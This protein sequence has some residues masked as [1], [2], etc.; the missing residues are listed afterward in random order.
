MTA[1]A[2]AATPT[3]ATPPRPRTIADLVE[4]HSPGFDALR[5]VLAFL[6]LVS[7]TWPL[8]GF[9]DEPRSPLAPTY[10]TLGGFAVAGFFAMSGLLVGRSAVRRPLGAFARAR[11]LRIVPGYATAVI[12]T[13]L[14]VAGLAWLHEH[15]GLAGF[16]DA[17][18][19]GPLG[20][21]GRW[22]LFGTDMV[23]GVQGVFTSSTPYGLASGS[24]FV[25]GSLWTLPYEVRC[26]L[27]IG[28][29]GLAVRRWG[30]QRSIGV[31]WALTGLVAVGYHQSPD[32]VGHTI[33]TVADRTL[34]ML[35]FVF[36]TGSLVG[37]F[38]DRVRLMGWM[39]FAA[40]A[41]ALVVG[42][43]SMFLSEH[44]GNAAL[45]VV[46]PSVAV[47]LAPAGAR[48]RGVDLSYGLYL[49]AWPVQMLL[50]MYG[51]DGN[52]WVFVFVATAITAVLAAASWFGIERP[53]VLRWG[54]TREP[55]TGVPR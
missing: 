12:V 4:Q 9:G 52:P 7:H 3:G 30:Q 10:L 16:V 36:L 44:L 34:V 42:R 18:P 17:S 5:L 29:V 51:L 38:A 11:V 41:I 49:Y 54:R 24:S 20:Y 33:G 28:M 55:M 48:L 32:L 2:E 39:P 8:G 19:E 23:H 50:A 13:A 27:V 35:L 6:V 31:A 14:P 43:W 26:Y 1:V 25:N 53:A 40:L 15:G 37:V 22:L 21:I 47:L 46:L 45:A